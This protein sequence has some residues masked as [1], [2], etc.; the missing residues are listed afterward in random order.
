M[1]TDHVQD[2]VDAVL[3]GHPVDGSGTDIDALSDLSEQED[4]TMVDTNTTSLGT[5]DFDEWG[6]NGY[7]GATA[8]R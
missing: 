4:A 2:G 7:R 6:P 5:M 3:E 8:R 1:D